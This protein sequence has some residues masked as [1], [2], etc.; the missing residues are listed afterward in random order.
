VPGTGGSSGGGSG[1]GGVGPEGGTPSD[2]S[3]DVG[4]EA[5]PDGSQ[6]ATV[7][8]AVV[9]EAA[10][11]GRG[12]ITSPGLI[13]CSAKCAVDVPEGSVVAVTA[14]ADPGST[15]TGWRGDALACASQATCSL[16]ASKPLH[17]TAEFQ[18]NV[19][20]TV[21]VDGRGQV[22][23]T[24]G[25]GMI[26]CPDACSETAALPASFSLHA[27]PGVGWLFDEWSGA[28]AESGE[29]C[30]LDLAADAPTLVSTEARFKQM[31]NWAQQVDGGGNTALDIAAGPNG[32]IVVAGYRSL[33]NSGLDVLVM[34]FSSTGEPLFSKAF[35]AS[36]STGHRTS[37]A[38][39]VSV[40]H[41]G[42]V[43]VA[44][45]FWGTID[46][47]GGP[48]SSAGGYDI[49]LAT[50]SPDGT[51]LASRAWG[52]AEWQ[53][54][55]ALKVAPDG[56]VLMGGTFR[57]TLSFGSALL[58]SAGDKDAFAVKLNSDGSEVWAARWGG[59][60]EESMLRVLPL[61]DGGAALLG[62]L[63]DAQMRL[64]RV[65]AL[66]SDLWA[67]DLPGHEP[68][69]FMWNDGCGLGATPSGDLIVSTMDQTTD[70]SYLARFS[71]DGALLAHKTFV[72]AELL[73]VAVDSAGDIVVVG[74]VHEGGG[75][76]GPP[77]P[78]RGAL[79]VLVG[80]LDSNLENRWSFAFGDGYSILHCASRVA[81]DGANN[82]L[83][84]GTN[85]TTLDLGP[86]P[87]TQG[88]DSSAMY[89]SSFRP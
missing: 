49:F 62:V 63:D 33:G 2:A 15:F 78:V 85:A 41:H 53:Q 40:D 70:S 60:G 45:S 69:L 55:R 20:L 24:G 58:T 64:L 7:P 46:F 36:D 50:F 42:N 65:D 3:P 52:D 82:I 47:G 18:H 61:A 19:Q 6:D 79:D 86:G 89:L 87:M 74:I 26:A 80:K 43:V 8:V 12:T 13:D 16:K 38:E 11:G 25:T 73:D 88:P 14:T 54:P 66:G 9:L 48:L 67:K 57:G 77:L 81:I 84:Y 17:I 22:R 76:G 28:C 59:P 23:S 29:D 51:H 21:S 34:G 71:P 68:N 83:F 31:Y 10:G 30:S 75:L 27:E 4:E 32:N 37:L 1:S 44:G 72:K 35:Q 39:A 56:S 5:E